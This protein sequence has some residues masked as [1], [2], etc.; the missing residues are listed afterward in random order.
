M[1]RLMSKISRTAG[2]RAAIP[3][4]PHWLLACLEASMSTRSPTLLM[5]STLAKSR[6]TLSWPSAQRVM[7]GASVILKSSDVE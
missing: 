7:W 6:I 4:E 1:K 3:S 2:C 5:Y